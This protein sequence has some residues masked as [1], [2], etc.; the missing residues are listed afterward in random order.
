MAWKD[1]IEMVEQMFQKWSVHCT[2]R[3]FNNE[4]DTWQERKKHTAE[5][6]PESEY[7]TQRTGQRKTNEPTN[8]RKEKRELHIEAKVKFNNA[9]FK[10]ARAQSSKVINHLRIVCIIS[11]I[12]MKSKYSK[13]KSIQ[14]WVCARTRCLCMYGKRA[15]EW[16]KER[17][18]EE[19]SHMIAAICVTA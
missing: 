18:E 5:N 6:S 3:A 9:S 15:I 10:R 14:T 1:H 8:E 11:L 7:S 2:E 12:N 4:K 13:Y 17:A 19:L 16:A